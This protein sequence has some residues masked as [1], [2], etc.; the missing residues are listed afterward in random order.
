MSKRWFK[1]GAGVGAVLL[2]SFGSCTASIMLLIL[3]KTKCK[4]GPGPMHH[5]FC[6]LPFFGYL[7]TLCGAMPR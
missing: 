6:V 5:D 3:T 7:D 2:M 4:D 1:A